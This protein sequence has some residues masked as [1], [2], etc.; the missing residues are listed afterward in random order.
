MGPCWPLVPTQ[1]IPPEDVDHP[2]GS[3]F[4]Y[5]KELTQIYNSHSK[6]NKRLFI[7]ELCKRPQPRAQIEATQRDVPMYLGNELLMNFSQC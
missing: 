3:T 5:L 4:R 1:V 7:L 2:W 6:R